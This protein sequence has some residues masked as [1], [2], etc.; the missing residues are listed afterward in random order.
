MQNVT[1][2]TQNITEDLD[3][4]CLLCFSFAEISSKYTSFK[5]FLYLYIDHVLNKGLCREQQNKFSKKKLPPV[6][7]EF[8]SSCVVL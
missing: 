1:A 3:S 8:G 7:I 4:L 5:F 6:G 2:F